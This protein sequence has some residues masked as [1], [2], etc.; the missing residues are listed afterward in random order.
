MIKSIV[1]AEKDGVFYE[2]DDNQ[3]WAINPAPV[4][5]PAR[6]DPPISLAQNA[7]VRF[8]TAWY[9]REDY[10]DSTTR[11]RRGRFYGEDGIGRPLWGYNRV[12]SWPRAPLPNV[13]ANVQID[14]VYRRIKI[15]T[16]RDEVIKDTVVSLGSAGYESDWRVIDVEQTT[17][18]ELLFTLK[19]IFPFGVLPRLR[20]EDQEV[21][22]AYE[23]VLDAT[24]K[25]APV[26][27][28]DVCRESSCV[29]LG[30]HFNVGGD[31]GDVIKK[32]PPDRLMVSWAASLI[33]WL[34]PRGKIAERQKQAEA[35]KRLRPVIDDDASLAVR[36]F[37]FILAELGYA[38]A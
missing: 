8:G 9:F 27:I 11:I 24:L 34:H 4:I 16:P 38:S 23:K 20:S 3:L 17:S 7:G 33:N 6:F 2:G 1:L 13:S 36:L 10:F 32:I 29:V 35:G 5:S 15:D 14:H 28:V 21:K 22:D 19:S 26:P 30:K 25:Y 31:L 12:S 37:G 18:D